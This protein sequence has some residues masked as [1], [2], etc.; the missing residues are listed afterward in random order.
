MLLRG[1]VLFESS[2]LMGSSTDLMMSHSMERG[3]NV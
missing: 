2:L 3:A 1:K